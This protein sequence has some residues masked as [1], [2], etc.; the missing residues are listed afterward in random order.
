MIVC[1]KLKSQLNQV[2]EKSNSCI[3]EEFDIVWTRLK[4]NIASKK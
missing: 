1:S 4:I 3:F 2:N